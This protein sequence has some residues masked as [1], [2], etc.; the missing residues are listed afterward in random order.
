MQQQMMIRQ[1]QEIINQQKAEAA[2]AAKAKAASDAMY[3]DIKVIVPAGVYP[4]SMFIVF[5]FKS[6]ETPPS[7]YSIPNT[8]ANHHV[9]PFKVNIN[10]SALEVVCPANV[11]PGS[12]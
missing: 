8:N 4:G 5:Y 3:D 6:F 12:E 9:V 1:Q 2:A 11:S 7:I 10:G